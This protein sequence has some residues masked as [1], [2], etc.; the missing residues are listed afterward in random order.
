MRSIDKKY[1][2]NAKN[3]HTK[4]LSITHDLEKEQDK[5]TKVKNKLKGIVEELNKT[6]EK[7]KMSRNKNDAQPVFKI[8]DNLEIQYQKIQNLIKPLL[9]KVDTLRKEEN[10]LYDFLVKSYPELT[11]DQIKQQVKDFVFEKAS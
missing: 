8:L 10:V 4:F 9:D 6:N 7:L 1:L 3:I 11:P 2:Q 5:L